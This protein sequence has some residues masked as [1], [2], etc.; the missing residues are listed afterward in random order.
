MIGKWVLFLQ[1]QINQACFNL[2]TLNTIKAG[3]YDLW[4]KFDL[5][6][7]DFE[8]H[9]IDR[10]LQQ[11]KLL[12]QYNHPPLRHQVKLA[13]AI[14]LSAGQWYLSYK[15]RQSNHLIKRQV[16]FQV[17][18]D[19]DVARYVCTEVGSEGTDL[20]P[21]IS[22][23]QSDSLV[24]QYLE[25]LETILNQQDRAVSSENESLSKTSIH[26]TP[27]PF[28][29]YQLPP[30]KPLASQVLPPKIESLSGS[31]Q[32]LIQL[33]KLTQDSPQP[34]SKTILI[35]SKVDSS[36]SLIIN[37]KAIGKLIDLV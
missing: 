18:R 4:G 35:T 5:S 21:S 34:K 19:R 24:N 12:C 27:L 7:I 32:S 2:T 11:K 36:N 25:E 37:P 22:D 6:I 1:S 23:R 20:N 16:A 33:P 26:L 15:I 30:L 3:K 29:P 17:D 10:Q 14:D 31:N 28:P 13:S 8:A 9:L